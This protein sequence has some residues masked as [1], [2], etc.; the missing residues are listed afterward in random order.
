[1]ESDFI[2]DQAAQPAPDYNTIFPA[3][4]LPHPAPLNMEQTGSQSQS[5]SLSP[6]DRIKACLDRFSQTLRAFW[7]KPHNEKTLYYC[8]GGL[9]CNR[10][11]KVIFD[12]L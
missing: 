7:R 2:P 3:G 5:G 11:K 4:L 8:V 10:A 12:R 9:A 6:N 1:M